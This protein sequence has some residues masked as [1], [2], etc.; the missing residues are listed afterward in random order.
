MRLLSI[1]RCVVSGRPGVPQRVLLLLLNFLLLVLGIF[2][3]CDDG[4][5]GATSRA[6]ATTAIAVSFMLLDFDILFSF[7]LNEERRLS[8]QSRLFSGKS[9]VCVEWSGVV[10]S[11]LLGSGTPSLNTHNSFSEGLADFH[12]FILQA[13][14][15][16]LSKIHNTA[17]I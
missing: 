2:F 16:N 7:C 1:L 9:I 10:C 12:S 15:T 17:D 13:E 3:S 11:V 6:F 14:I 4:C 8:L 5:N